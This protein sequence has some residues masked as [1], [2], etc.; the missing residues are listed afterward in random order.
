MLAHPSLPAARIW[1]SSYRTAGGACSPARPNLA[2]HTIGGACDCRAGAACP[3]AAYDCRPAAQR[4]DRS[5]CYATRCGLTDVSHG[6]TVVGFLLDV[7][8][9]NERTAGAEVVPRATIDGLAATLRDAI[10]CGQ[11][12]GADQVLAASVFIDGFTDGAQVGC[13]IR[14]PASVAGKRDAQRRALALGWLRLARVTPA[15][16][17]L[18]GAWVTMVDGHASLRDRTAVDTQALFIRL[19]AGRL[20]GEDHLLDARSCTLCPRP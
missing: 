19:L 6:N 13:G 20:L 8:M 1:G 12:P 9:N 14:S 2:C 11:T 3:E 4:G 17:P 15:L 16:L 5:T 18:V 10:W 7:N